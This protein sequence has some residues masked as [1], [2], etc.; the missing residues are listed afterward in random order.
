LKAISLLI[1]APE[2]EALVR[3]RNN[4]RN[5]LKAAPD[6]RCEIVVNAGA[7]ASALDQPDPETDALLRICGNTLQQ[8]GLI[9]PEGLTVVVAAVLHLAER[10][11]D[12]WQYIRA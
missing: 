9:P 6:A 7:V 8:T 2:P 4:A 10:Q 11:R 5:L 1:H 12:G 3:A